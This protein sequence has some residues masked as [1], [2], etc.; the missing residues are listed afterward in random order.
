MI[1]ASFYAISSL[2][3]LQTNILNALNTHKMGIFNNTG[4]FYP[5]STIGITALNYII[6][7]VEIVQV[8]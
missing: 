7:D 6:S 8:A 1:Y 4:Y 3:S 2:I 5:V